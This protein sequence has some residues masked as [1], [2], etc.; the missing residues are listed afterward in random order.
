MNSTVTA[1]LHRPRPETGQR[2]EC[3]GGEHASARRR[4][5]GRAAVAAGTWKRS[6]S[7]S[8]PRSE[9]PRILGRRRVRL[10]S[11]R[12]G[13][14]PSDHV[15]GVGVVAEVRGQGRDRILVARERI[16]AIDAAVVEPVGEN[17]RA[18]RRL[19]RLASA[20]REQA[21][22]RESGDEGKQKSARSREK[23]VNVFSDAYPV[24][25]VSKRRERL[26][27]ATRSGGRRRSR[28]PRRRVPRRVAVTGSRDRRRRAA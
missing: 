5:V 19:G 6:R 20:R 18:A 25:L 27:R 7:R 14:G 4:R 17:R 16:H 23:S 11:S 21:G 9:P 24:R 13:Q 3:T 22:K 8:R 15:G 1:L 12:T 26:A 10:R 28:E 2:T